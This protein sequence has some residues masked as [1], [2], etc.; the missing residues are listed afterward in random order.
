MINTSK[1]FFEKCFDEKP[2]ISSFARGRVNLI[3]DHTDYNFGFVMPTPLSLGIEV[4]LTPSETG[5]IEG[6][7][8]IFREFKRPIHYR[9]DGTW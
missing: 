3:G 4:S 5:L 8:E 2:L 1:K 6:K 9:T 7:S